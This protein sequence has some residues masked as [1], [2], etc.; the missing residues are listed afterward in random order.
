MREVFEGYGL[1]RIGGDELL[2]PCPEIS[3]AKL[4]DKVQKLRE[5]AKKN[6]VVLA[7]GT[8]WQSKAEED[9]DW[10]LKVSEKRMYEDKAKYYESTGID[11]RKY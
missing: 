2:V 9:I 3:E 7:V 4:Q 10:M 1:F 8:M 5:T 6:D 11:R